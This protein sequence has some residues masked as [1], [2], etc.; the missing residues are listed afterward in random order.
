MWYERDIEI[1]MKIL[2]KKSRI[3]PWYI[4]IVHT[5]ILGTLHYLVNFLKPGLEKGCGWQEISKPT[6][7]SHISCHEF[8][9]TSYKKAKVKSILKKEISIRFHGYWNIFMKR[10]CSK[11]SLHY[12]SPDSW[13]LEMS[14]NLSTASWRLKMVLYVCLLKFIS[15]YIN[16]KPKLTRSSQG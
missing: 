9:Y 13:T 1:S 5:I 15:F 2:S 14:T 10:K 3:F 12:A 11:N 8:F 7:Y 6:Q 16:K 4:I